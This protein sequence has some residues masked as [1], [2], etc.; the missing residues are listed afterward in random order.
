[1]SRL[2]DNT[3]INGI[4]LFRFGR[5]RKRMRK[6]LFLPLLML[7]AAQA[8]NAAPNDQFV[9]D[10]IA[11]QSTVRVWEADFKQTRQLKALTEPLVEVRK[12]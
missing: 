9:D 2:C 7:M 11:A 3:L 10:W 5:L 6:Q 1:M 4:I 12:A 8:S